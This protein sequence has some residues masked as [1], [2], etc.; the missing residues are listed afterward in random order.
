M[1]IDNLQAYGKTLAYALKHPHLV[2]TI[3]VTWRF[4][5]NGKNGEKKT[6][7]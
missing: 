6:F 3:N 4:Q 7:V 2:H 1:N 5:K